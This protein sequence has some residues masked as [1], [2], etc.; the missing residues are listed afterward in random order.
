[1]VPGLSIPQ[2]ELLGLD[3]FDDFVVL[4]ELDYPLAEA[5]CGVGG[6]LDA[7]RTE[8]G[9]FQEL[10]VDPLH[11]C[12]GDVALVVVLELGHEVPFTHELLRGVPPVV[13]EL[14]RIVLLGCP[15]DF[16]VAHDAH[17][18]QNHLHMLGWML[19]DPD[20]VDMGG[21][22]GMEGIIC[23]LQDGPGLGELVLAHNLT[24]LGLHSDR[25]CLLFL[26][27]D[28]PLPRL[29]LSLSRLLEL[30]LFELCAH[31]QLLKPR[32]LLVDLL[33]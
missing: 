11:N 12:R 18:M 14:L 7:L 31:L 32:L 10:S 22:D 33:L 17:G 24:L 13:L 26:L 6:L 5:F 21:L 3:E 4:F 25:I 8:L 15:F 19:Q 23:G 2:I 28:L 20:L 27:L 9:V 30:S 16:S 29:D 1:M